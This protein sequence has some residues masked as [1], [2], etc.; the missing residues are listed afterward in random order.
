M[1]SDESMPNGGLF[2]QSSTFPRSPSEKDS[3]STP[4]CIIR[5]ESETGKIRATYE[6]HQA[7]HESLLRAEMLSC[8]A[9]RTSSV[10]SP[11]LFVAASYLR[12]W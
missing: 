12:H 10:T 1:S 7:S 3:G 6:D 2:D 4:S 5:W 8:L 11:R 9:V